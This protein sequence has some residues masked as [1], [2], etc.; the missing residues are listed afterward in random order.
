[1]KTKDIFDLAARIAGLVVFVYGMG[2]VL[3]GLCG[4]MDLIETKYTKY[5]AFTGV[6]EVIVGL[7]IMRAV[8]P[9]ADIAFPPREPQAD[10]K[11]E[12]EKPTE[13]NEAKVP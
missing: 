4:A 3:Y 7:M 1:M 6:V 9:L 10:E 11:T 13:N 5:N 12:I 2:H 8:I